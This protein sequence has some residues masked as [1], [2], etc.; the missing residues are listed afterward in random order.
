MTINELEKQIQEKA[1]KEVVDEIEK[2]LTTIKNVWRN[3]NN[4]INTEEIIS[5]I[6]VIDKKRVKKRPLVLYDTDVPENAIERASKQITERILDQLD[7]K[8]DE[9]KINE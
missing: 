9:K 7:K 1:R 6:N 3:S 4:I 2:V 8:K 5:V